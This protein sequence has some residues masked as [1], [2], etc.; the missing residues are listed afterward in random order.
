MTVR[1]INTTTRLPVDACIERVLHEAMDTRFIDRLKHGHHRTSQIAVLFVS[2]FELDQDPSQKGQEEGSMDLWGCYTPHHRVFHRPVI[3]VSPEKIIKSCVAFRGREA[4]K[5]SLE[6]CFPVL[7]AAVVIHELGHWLMDARDETWHFDTPWRWAAQALSD[8]PKRNVTWS[9]PCVLC[10]NGDPGL[11]Q[12]ESFIEE[13]LANAIVLKQRFKPRS[14]KFLEAVIKKQ[15][16]GYR[17]APQWSGS[18]QQT[19]DTADAWRTHKRD[20]RPQVVSNLRTRLSNGE[21]FRES[22]FQ[23]GDQDAA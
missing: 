19:L 7:V 9:G 17:H 18:L 13:S 3:R 5:L 16:D 12:D 15:R 11:G 10:S 23:A 1:A 4:G 6:E 14:M 22:R 8:D 2:D 21:E 20:P